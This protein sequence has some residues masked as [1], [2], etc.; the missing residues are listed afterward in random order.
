MLRRPR[1]SDAN[2]IVALYREAFG[3]A[4]PIDAE[5][6][7]RS[8]RSTQLDPD[9]FRVL[10]LEG[11]VVGY[12]DV[13]VADEWVG[14]EAAAPGHWEPL[15]EWAEGLAR[16]AGRRAVRAHSYGGTEL[17]EVAG[18]RGYLCRQHGF[19]MQVD[20]GDE[21]PDPPRYPHELAVR[22]LGDG[23]AEAVRSLLNEAFAD[24]PFHAELSPAAFRES[25]LGG[26]GFDPALWW[27]A[28]DEGELAGFMLAFPEHAGDQVG[29]LET[30]AVRPR[31]RRHGLGEALMRAA[32]RELHARGFRSV[33][34][35]VDGSNDGAVRLYERL[36]FRVAYRWESWERSLQGFE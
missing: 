11:R 14:L 27:L 12:G 28:W 17:P 1:E 9:W 24:D 22:P 30:L 2:A 34:L 3:D 20:L 35:G 19:T 4:R 8:L 25:Y 23:D 36:G 21:P 32:I 29:W 5:E 33:G 31:W 15:L 13:F 10:E 7:R 18:S 6:V 16:A 26:R